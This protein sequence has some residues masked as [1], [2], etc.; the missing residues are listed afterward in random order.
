MPDVVYDAIVGSSV[1]LRQVTQSSYDPK[2]ESLQGRMS[3]SAVISDQFVVSSSPEV[4]LTTLDL[5]GFMTA[6][7]TLGTKVSDGSNTLVPYQK[8]ASGGT[9]AGGSSNFTLAGTAPTNSVP[10]PVILIPESINVPRVGAPHATGKLCYLSGDGVTCPVTE[11][12]NQA[13]SSEAFAAM[14]GMGPVYINS[15][16][17]ARNVGFTINFGLGWSEKQHYDGAV[18][19]SDMFLET[20]DPTIEVQVEDFD[21]MAS[22]MPAGTISQ[23][24]CYIRKRASGGTYVADS[25]TVHIKFSF[26]NG[27]IK[28]MPLSASE[29]KHGNAAIRIEGRTLTVSTASAV[30]NP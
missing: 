22:I 9:F 24:S 2:V 28:P 12:V 19:P 17:V 16:R 15:T 20:I 6:F 3:G 14:F 21:Q 30:G 4:N 8:R 29:T 5:A 25:S 1:N 13:L 18:Y 10:H 27:L 11:N 23:F 7:G 26:S